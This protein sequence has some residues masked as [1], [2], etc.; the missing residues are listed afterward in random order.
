MMVQASTFAYCFSLNSALYANVNLDY[1]PL[2]CGVFEFVI[3]VV[4]SM[5]EKHKMI[6]N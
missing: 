5:S 1:V 2:Y 3:E 6:C 4:L